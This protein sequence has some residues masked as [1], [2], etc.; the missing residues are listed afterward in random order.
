MDVLC[1]APTHN[2][3]AGISLSYK[4]LWW[5][6]YLCIDLMELGFSFLVSV[7]IS[8]SSVSYFVGIMD[9]AKW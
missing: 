2:K 5:T 4:L 9:K 7:E 1:P 8:V 3:S 6:V